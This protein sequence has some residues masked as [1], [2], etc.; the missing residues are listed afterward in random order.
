MGFNLGHLLFGQSGA[1]ASINLFNK[2]S[3]QQ[4]QMLNQ[5]VGFQQLGINQLGGAF[6]QASKAATQQAGAAKQES[7]DIATSALGASQ[8]SA[9]GRGLFNTSTFDAVNRGIGSDLMRH[10]SMID[11][12]AGQQ[13]G[14]I[15]MARGNALNQAYGQMGGLYSAFGQNQA[16][17]AQPLFGVVGQ[18]QPGILGPLIGA[19]GTYF[20][21]QS[22]G[23]HS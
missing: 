10:L 16:A 13:Q 7:R 18:G 11:A 21:L 23:S 5:A 19:A 8:N 20:G 1:G 9:I 15:A 22:H 3:M 4:Q 14:Q 2:L 17:L 6:D 12:M